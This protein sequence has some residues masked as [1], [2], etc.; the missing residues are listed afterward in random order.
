[1]ERKSFRSSN[2]KPLSSAI[3]KTRFST[4]FCVSFKFSN[5]RKA[6]DQGPKPWRAQD[7]PAPRRRPRIPRD[8]LQK[9]SPS[10]GVGLCVPA[11]LDSV[12][13][14]SPDPKHHL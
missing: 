3:L 1:M 14:V 2:S 12:P 6:T 5:G 8:N 10:D 4:P 7:G 11:F 9:R 13:L